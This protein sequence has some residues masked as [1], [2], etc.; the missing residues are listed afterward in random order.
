MAIDVH[1][2][3][4]GIGGMRRHGVVSSLVGSI[5]IRKPFGFFEGFELFDDTAGILGIVFGDS[6]FNVRSIK[7]HQGGFFLINALA[8]RFGQLHKMVEHGL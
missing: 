3:D 8:D 1:L 6:G 2:L 4:G 5:G 7:E